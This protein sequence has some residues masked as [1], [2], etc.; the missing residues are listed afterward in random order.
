MDRKRTIGVTETRVGLSL[1]TCALLVFGYVAIHRFGGSGPE[2][3]VEFRTGSSSEPDGT[4]AGRDSG[5]TE[6]PQILPVQGADRP[7]S[8]AIHTSQRPTWL[9]PLTVDG[10]DDSESNNDSFWPT[11]PGGIG[12]IPRNEEQLPR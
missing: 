1:L 3:P 11:L 7:N 9:P 5:N 2:P 12:D 6:G 10:R 8:P 4:A